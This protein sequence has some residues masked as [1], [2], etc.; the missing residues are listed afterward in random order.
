VNITVKQPSQNVTIVYWCEQTVPMATDKK[1]Q[2]NYV[3]H[4]LFSHAPWWM[5]P[6]YDPHV[7]Y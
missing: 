3:L 1:E 6:M 7:C 2:R 4:R 5:C